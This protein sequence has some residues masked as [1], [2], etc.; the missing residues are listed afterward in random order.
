LR[1]VGARN[2]R[3]TVMIYKPV[4]LFLLIFLAGCALPAIKQDKDLATLMEAYRERNAQLLEQRKRRQEQGIKTLEV[5]RSDPTKEFLVSVNLANASLPVVVERLLDDTKTPYLLESVELAGRVTARF[6]N[7]PFSQALNIILGSQG[8]SSVKREGILVIR[9]GRQDVSLGPGPPSAA[10]SP[11][12][13]ASAATASTEPPTQ[14]EIPV[15]HADMTTLSSLLDALFPVNPQTG[16][17]PV[18]YGMQ[19][20]TSTLFLSGAPQDLAKAVSVISRADRDPSHVVLEFLVVEFDSDAVEQFG[21]DISGL[22]QGRFSD[23]STS[24]SSLTGRAITFT[25]TAGIDRGLQYTAAIDALISQEK[26][27]VISRPYV[28]TRSGKQA[29]INITRDRYVLVQVPQQG[30]AV[31]T[32]QAVSSGVLLNVTPTVLA[33]GM[34]R[35]DV[36]VEDSQFVPTAG[37]IAVEVDK[38][39]ATTNAQVESGQSIIIGGLTLNRESYSNAGL[40]WFRRLPLVNLLVSDQ[41]RTQTKQEVVIFVTPHIWT[42]DLDVPLAAKEA[43]TIKEEEEGILKP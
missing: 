15:K 7:V 43:F 27:K 25:N 35:M 22:R 8:Y 32:T 12:A 20:F 18:L 21:V 10:P 40:P 36:D 34:V 37:N 14:I 9:A 24:F 33:D 13:A 2:L 1:S 6:D 19:P 26:A 17:K 30:A 42:P 11:G 3:L 38:N 41:E 4:G 31:T 28:A 23:L 39:K 5:V 29:T 16:S